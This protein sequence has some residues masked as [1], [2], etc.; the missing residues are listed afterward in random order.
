MRYI[1]FLV[2]IVIVIVI[3]AYVNFDKNDQSLDNG[4]DA[5]VLSDSWVNYNQVIWEGNEVKDI[6]GYSPPSI[7]S[8]LSC[9]ADFSNDLDVS[10]NG[11][12][13]K[14]NWLVARIGLNDFQDL[15]NKMGLS[16]V[17]ELAKTWPEALECVENFSDKW[18]VSKSVDVNTFFGE[19]KDRKCFVVAKYEGGKIYIK[20]STYY[21]VKIDE[22][23]QM[24]LKVIRKN[25]GN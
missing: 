16:N 5:K 4:E 15:T 14:S 21:E 10:G 20:K 6:I 11:V 24:L 13:I 1:I 25:L 8:D 19:D 7:M 3:V 23:R 18:A 2:V 12:G 17:Y 9:Y 22:D